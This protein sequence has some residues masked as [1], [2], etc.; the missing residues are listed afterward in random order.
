MVDVDIRGADDI[1]K[2]VTAIRTHADAK[3]LRKE[4]YS[5]LNRVT[6]EI[7]GNLVEVIPAALPRRGGLAALMQTKTRA[8]TTAKSGK[9]AGVSMRFEAKGHDIRTLTGKRLRHPVFGNRRVWV[10]QAEGV[11]PS[12]FMGEFEKQKP[13]IQD[14]ILTV[15][16]DVA[17]K[18]TS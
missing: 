18:V 5:G 1:D 7:R 15:L 13:H 9:W 4:L 10:D 2:L 14:A 17:R 11:E 6:K 3:A 12:V 16:N 8:R